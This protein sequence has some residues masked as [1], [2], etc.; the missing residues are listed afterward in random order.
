MHSLVRCRAVL[1]IGISGILWPAPAA[2]GVPSNGR[3]AYLR[4]DLVPEQVFSI[5]PD[6]TG[7]MRITDSSSWGS[8]RLA[9]SPAGGRLAVSQFNGVASRLATVRAEGTRLRVVIPAKNTS[10][11]SVDWTPD[12]SKL[13]FTQRL[14]TGGYGIFS[15]NLDGS[16]RTRLGSSKAFE[17]TP[18]P[19]G[20]MLAVV[21]GA[22][23]LA[24]LDADG[25]NR[26]IIVNDGFNS[27]PDWSPDGSAI[28]FARVAPGGQRSD[29]FVV[30]PN[31]SGLARLAPTARRQE[32]QPSWS[33]DGTRIV[34]A[35][36]QSRDFSAPYDLFTIG[37][38]GSNE[39]QVT[40]TAS[41]NEFAPSWMAG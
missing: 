27:N 40:D 6:G 29:L 41:R 10:Y 14:R 31:G 24:I 36:Q 18:S 1:L 33:P 20:S 19:D 5:L 25:T 22:D 26:Q 11:G 39:E 7:A 4:F 38:G 30:Q 15:V 28:V 21:D 23:R 8:I 35:R 13:L 17:V 16:G 12:G 37:A 3:I 9:A 34:F 2:A 32:Y